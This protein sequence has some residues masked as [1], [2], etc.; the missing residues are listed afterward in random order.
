MK[1]KVQH[2]TN[3]YSVIEGNA[4]VAGYIQ[5]LRTARLIAAAPEMRE[6]LEWFLDRLKAEIGGDDEE[7]RE[8]R[9]LLDRIKEGA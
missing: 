9:V 7:M 8:A 1:W 6:K 2:D 5:S 4:R 3:D